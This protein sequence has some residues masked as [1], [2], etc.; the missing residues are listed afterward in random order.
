MLPAQELGRPLYLLAK[1]GAF[2]GPIVQLVL[3]KLDKGTCGAESCAHCCQIG[4]GI[5]LAVAV[6]RRALLC[7]RA[8]VHVR[9]C[10]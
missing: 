7:T 3:A 5:V 6:N 2:D 10:I 9:A 8:C 1:G 4:P